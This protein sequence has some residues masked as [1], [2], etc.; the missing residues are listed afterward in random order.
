MTLVLSIPS[1]LKHGKCIWKKY[2]SLFPLLDHCRSEMLFFLF[3]PYTSSLRVYSKH[4]NRRDSVNCRLSL[5]V[6]TLLCVSLILFCDK[7]YVVSFIRCISLLIRL[8]K[9]YFFLSLYK[10]NRWPSW[11]CLYY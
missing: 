1:Y 6:L 9:L 8:K 2:I 4:L 3:L 11:V 5:A 7:K 10:R